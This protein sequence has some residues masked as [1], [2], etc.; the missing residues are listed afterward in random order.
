[1]RK[2]RVNVII[3][4]VVV[5]T[6]ALLIIQAFQTRQLFDKKS[7]QFKAE[8]QTTLERIAVRHEKAE[9]VR[10]FFRIA[11]TNFTGHYKDILKEEFQDLLSARE[12]ISIKD[13]TIF[14]NG[15]SEN[16]LVIQGQSIDSIIGLKAEQRVL[17]RDVRQL[18]DFYHNKSAVDTVGV[19]IHLDK[20]V[21]KKMFEKAKFV[22]DMMMQ[23]FRENVFESPEQSFD[24][25][26]LDSVIRTEF[27]D[28][29]L[30]SKFQFVVTNESGK[31][32]KSDGTVEFYDKNLELDNSFKTN[33]F[34]SNL[35][36]EHLQLHIVFP[37]QNS[38]L[39][40][41]LFLPLL[42]NL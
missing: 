13:T 42:V 33:L 21:I 37:R 22:N 39:L 6:I 1:V 23:A 28:D 14:E 24:I 36:N 3:V 20:K 18:R 32:L 10:K 4:F 25:A 19:A 7:G 11:N 2:I 5:A 8:V 29:K 26:F 34:P 16:Y 31:P 15:Q 30:P 17:A 12:T 40:G 38:I 27:K 9:D 41:E 35:F